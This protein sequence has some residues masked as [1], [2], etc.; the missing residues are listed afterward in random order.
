LKPEKAKEIIWYEFMATTHLDEASW[1]DKISDA[2]NY[3]IDCAYGAG[4]D[5]R[6]NTILY[7]QGKAVL[8]LNEYGHIIQIHPSINT[9]AKRMNGNASNIRAVIQGRQHTAY[10]YCWRFKDDIYYRKED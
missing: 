5:Y 9:A 3:A 8:Q 7:K 2:L 4:F 6:A 1:A 10:G